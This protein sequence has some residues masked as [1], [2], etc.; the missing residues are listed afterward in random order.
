[1]KH[2]A[3]FA[4]AWS[5]MA[6]AAGVP[7]TTTPKVEPAKADSHSR[8]V[9]A[10]EKT[11]IEIRTAVLES[12]LLTLP[13]NEKVAI[14]FAGD[15]KNWL[16]Q[17]TKVPTRYLS[18]KPMTAHTQTNLHIITDHGNDYSFLLREVSGSAEPYDVKV[19]IEA[20]DQ[21]MKE[22]IQAAPVMV[23]ADESERAK[24]EAELAKKEAEAAIKAAEN[25]AAVDVSAYRES[26]PAKMNFAYEWNR[27]KGDKLGLE[28][29][30]NDDKFTYFRAHPQEAPALYELKDGKPSLVNFD[31]RDGVYTVTKLMDAGWLAVGKTQVDFRR[32]GK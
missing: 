3:A 21:R 31:L 7:T 32:I 4:L 27:V 9:E 12:T 17:A 13:E 1:M 28:Q 29:I 23:S 26:Y 18:V 5:G 30:W 15:T 22:N 16:I 2:T 19:F 24:H 11:V 10:T 14:T 8:V 25:K 6:F 20:T